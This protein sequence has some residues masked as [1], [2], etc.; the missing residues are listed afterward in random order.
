ME[1][2]PEP[3]T[4]KAN[5]TKLDQLEA[6]LDR[7]DVWSRADQAWILAELRKAWARLE[8]SEAWIPADP[9]RIG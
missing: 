4:E 9:S 1:H 3:V 2:Q 8:D 5:V 6:A 7:D